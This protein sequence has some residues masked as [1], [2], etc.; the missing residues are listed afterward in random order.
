MIVSD[1]FLNLEGR[2]GALAL[3][4]FDGVHRGHAAII[5]KAVALGRETGL[6]SA[7]MTFR[8]HP[9]ELFG[10]EVPLLS[11]PEQNRELLGNLGIDVLIEHPFTPEFSNMQPAEFV[12]YMATA[13][14]PLDLVVGFNY[15]FGARGQGSTRELTEMGAA[16]GLRVHEIAPVIIGGDIVS[17]SRIRRLTEAG[18]LAEAELLLGRRFNLQGE[19]VHGDGRGAGLGFPTANLR[20]DYRPVLPPFGV[21]VV[22]TPG[23]GYGVANLGVR[24]TYPLDK[25]QLE[26]FFLEAGSTDLYGHSLVVEL[27]SFIRPEVSFANVNDLIRQI[28]IDIESARRII[29][30]NP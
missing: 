10:R 9:L 25:P 24:P 26:V 8:P 3:G 17:S 14:S 27:I 11:S 29:Y 15:S 30:H 20:F 6:L 28:E 1:R 12:D 7:A 13:L 4:M 21:Y 19:V 18:K 5:S 16:R 2:L 22:R 23:I